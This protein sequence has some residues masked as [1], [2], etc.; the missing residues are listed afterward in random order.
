MAGAW[1]GRLV[2][3]S[4]RAVLQ[5]RIDRLSPEEKRLLQTVA[6][7]GERFALLLLHRLLSDVTPEEIN[8]RLQRLLAA[9]FVYEASLLP[10]PRYAFIHALTQEVAYEGLLQE[11][12]L[13]IHAALVSVLEATYSARLAEHAE[14]LAYHAV[15]GELWG[16]VALYARQA[17]MRAAGQSAYREAVR[18]FEQAIAAFA[19]LPTSTATTAAAIETRFE[20][21]NALFPLGE[22]QRDLE[23]LGAAERLARTAGDVQRLP[24]IIAYIARDLGLLGHPDEA[25]EASGRALALADAGG[26]TNLRILARSY[27]GQAHYALGDF[28]AAA[29]IMHD[30]L[31]DIGESDLHATYGLPFSGRTAFRCW[32]A[33]ALARLGPSAELVAVEAALLAEDATSDDPLCATVAQYS[34]GFGA[35]G[36]DDCATA[37]ERLE[38]ALRRCQHWDFTAW[39]TNI[40]SALGHAYARLGRVE[41]GLD[42]LWRAVRRSRALRLMVSHS[43]EVAWLADATLAA[44]RVE[45]ARALAAEAVELARRYQERGNE[46]YALFVSGTV[47]R[48]GRDQTEDAAEEMFGEALR[49]ALA[50]GMEPLVVRCRRALRRSEAECA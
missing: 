5:A 17:G 50:C 14:V 29:K 26:D 11:R 38:E 32:W 6:V 13:Q 35:L 20:L 47:A 1:S 43:L 8:A 7:I 27:A 42:L 23:S 24:W 31:R 28:S 41:E 36:R 25:L 4:V 44:G 10:E 33:W 9:G 15:R 22:I 46:A 16:R 37:I 30:L 3:S 45:E 49:A 48:R 18:Q 2:P 39:F 19:R 34:A 40:A 21:R 12:R